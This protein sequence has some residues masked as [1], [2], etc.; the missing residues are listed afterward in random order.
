MW[1]RIFNIFYERSG[2]LATI[3]SES[4]RK[5]FVRMLQETNRQGPVQAWL[6]VHELF[7]GG[8]WVTVNGDPFVTT[9]YAKWA[10]TANFVWGNQ[11]DNLGGHQDCMSII[12]GEAGA[13]D[14]ENCNMLNIFFCKITA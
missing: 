10:T 1:N 8:D 14:D 7:G 11:P 12:S 9:E 4:E 3:T 13:L 6:G 2:Q 5:L